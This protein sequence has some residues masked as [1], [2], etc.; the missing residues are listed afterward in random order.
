MKPESEDLIVADITAWPNM[1]NLP[2]RV[3]KAIRIEGRYREV[4][5]DATT[6][7]VLGFVSLQGF[8]DSYEDI[9]NLNGWYWKVRCHTAMADG[10]TTYTLE[11]AAG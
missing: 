7:K 11:R 9:Y 2:E 6:G 10:Q 4:K 1:V 3:L 5:I 8:Y